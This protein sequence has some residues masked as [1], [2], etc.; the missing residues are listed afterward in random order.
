[1]KKCPYCAEEIQDGAIKC[2]HCGE[3]LA[4]AGQRPPAPPPAR[5]SGQPLVKVAG[6]L[7]LLV[8]LGTVFYF[9]MFYDTGVDVPSAN[10]GGYEVGGG[11]V[12]NVG[13]MQNRQNGIIVGSVV[14]A[15]GLACFLI[16]LY[17]RG[18]ST[19][20]TGSVGIKLPSPRTVIP[21]LVALGVLLGITLVI[22]KI[23]Q[24]NGESKQMQQMRF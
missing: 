23:R 17:A 4:A 12:H 5:K 21:I 18:S 19:S 8:G 24:Y 3:M 7:L 1:M 10:I 14:A 13:L 16:G 22:H 15:A 9:L 2:K 20:T 11:K 6:L